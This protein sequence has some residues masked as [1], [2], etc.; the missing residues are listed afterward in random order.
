[1][2]KSEFRTLEAGDVVGHR[3]LAGEYI[4]ANV[5]KWNDWDYDNLTDSGA[6][7]CIPYTWAITTTDGRYMKEEDR[8]VTDLYLIKR[9]AT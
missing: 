3:M 1:M 5:Q 8:D 2:N 6:P 7:T 9:G 4:I